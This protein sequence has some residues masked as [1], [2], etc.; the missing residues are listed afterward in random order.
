[1]KRNE[2]KDTKHF[3]KK[4]KCQNHLKTKL[5]PVCS[6]P[7]CNEGLRRAVCRLPLLVSVCLSHLMTA[8]CQGKESLSQQRHS[9]LQPKR[10]QKLKTLLAPESKNLA[11][12]EEQVPNMLTQFWNS[13]SFSPA[14]NQ[15]GSTLQ[16]PTCLARGMT[17]GRDQNKVKVINEL[18]L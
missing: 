5:E 14:Q 10:K 8:F 13:V 7:K 17:R 1:M 16:I 3:Q 11:T 4:Q 6:C 12:L 9:V 15:S 2:R 18:M